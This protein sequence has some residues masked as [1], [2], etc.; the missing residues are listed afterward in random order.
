M[1]LY[2]LNFQS[3]TKKL[4]QAL[5]KS[6]KIPQVLLFYGP[7][8][9]GKRTFAKAFARELLHYFSPTKERSDF[10]LSRETHPDLRYYPSDPKSL[11]FPI[12]KVR[13]LIQDIDLAPFESFCKVFILED[14]EKMLASSGNLLLKSLEE[15]PLDTYVIL[16][17]SSKTWMASCLWPIKR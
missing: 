17:A 11:S 4:L 6:K 13:E 14:I 2:E 1:Q 9:T 8:G 3:P 5:L 7:S 10:K 15:P 16:I 12:Q